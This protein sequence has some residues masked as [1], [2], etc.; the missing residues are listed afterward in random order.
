MRK[1]LVT[2]L[3]LWAVSAVADACSCVTSLSPCHKEW[4]SKET[5]FFGK[6]SAV[7]DNEGQP[8]TNDSRQLSNHEVHFTSVEFFRGG[9]AAR[10]AVVFTGS[11]GG[12]CGYPFVVGTSYLVYAFTNNGRLMTG[13]CS[14]T[15]PEVIVG[16]VLRELRA[17]RDTGRIDD[18]FG[19]IGMASKGVGWEDLVET[20][21]L[22]GIP[23]HADNEEG[24]HFTTKTDEHGAYAFAPLPLGKYQ[25]GVGLPA[26]LTMPHDG[27]IQ[28]FSA[29]IQSEATGA[30]CRIDIFSR[31]DGRISGKIIDLNGVGAAGFITLQPADP[32][33]AAAA[34]RRGGQ[35]G[36]DTD[37]GNFSLTELPP[38]KYRLVFHPKIGRYINFQSAFYWPTA[39]SGAA[40]NGIEISLGQHIE[41]VRFEAPFYGK[42]LLNQ[43]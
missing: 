13:I 29:E 26:G 7:L 5:I 38:G 27:N 35:P 32:Q 28:P 34:R 30:G 39:T 14:Q 4:N 10:E 22:P 3:L 9:K 20:R 18:L 24:R 40:P 16:G 25:V 36:E 37:D 23:V 41:N 12:D 8:I 1:L 31:P 17:L 21:P 2:P 43:H 15:A 42:P 11:G 19:T 33:E 6:V